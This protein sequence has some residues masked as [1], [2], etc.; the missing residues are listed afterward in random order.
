MAQS[1]AK[2]VVHWPVAASPDKI[3]IL[4]QVL[5][6][7]SEPILKGSELDNLAFEQSAA[8]SRFDEARVLTEQ[9]LGLITSTK[10]GLQLTLR[11]KTILKKR[12]A[13]QLDLL[14][15]LFYTAWNAEQPSQHV[16]SWFYRTICQELWAG[17]SLNLDHPARISLTQQITNQALADFHS[18]PNFAPEKFSIGIQTM[19]GALKW[20]ECLRPLVYKDEKFNRRS[21][22]SAELFLLA[23]S[24]SYQNSKSAIGM[25]LLLAPQRRD[26]ICKLCLLDPLYFDRMLDWV[27]PIYSQ[28]LAQ[29]TRSGS[30]GRFIRLL[31]FVTVEDLQS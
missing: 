17:Q 26:E 25:D 23:L 8:E 27:L 4:L 2:L 20:L 9:S 5:L 10:E 1:S 31:R 6:S 29:G 3:L 19:A 21:A 12:E 16:K 22:C 15:Y 7:A 30:Y 13:I 28:F 24:Q 11:A 18:L 14:H